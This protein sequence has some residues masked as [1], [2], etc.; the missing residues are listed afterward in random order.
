[1]SRSLNS[2]HTATVNS[3]RFIWSISCFMRSMGTG[4]PDAIPVRSLLR[5]TAFPQF[6]LLSNSDNT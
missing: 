6:L 5:S 3:V 4:D 1:M 2:F